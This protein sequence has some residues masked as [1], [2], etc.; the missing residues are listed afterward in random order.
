[1]DPRARNKTNLLHRDELL[2]GVP[3]SQL[4]GV[5][6]LPSF[7]LWVGRQLRVELQPFPAQRPIFRFF[8]RRIGTRPCS[9]VQLVA[10]LAL[11]LNRTA[12]G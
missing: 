10:C 5:T 4:A 7:Q 11:G 8:S 6:V 3:A 2:Q 9:T 1:M 12:D